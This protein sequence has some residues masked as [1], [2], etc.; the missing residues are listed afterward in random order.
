MRIF[1][2]FLISF[3]LLQSSCKY[4]SDEKLQ[5]AGISQ[6]DSLF[7]DFA[8]S[9]DTLVLEKKQ[10]LA[11]QL[12]SLYA[13]LDPVERQNYHAIL[14]SK[15]FKDY[16]SIS[17]LSTID[18]QG[19]STELREYLDFYKL[20]Y[21]VPLNGTPELEV[22]Q[23]ILKKVNQEGAEKNR[24]TYL[25]YEALARIYFNNAD[26]EKSIHYI[27]LWYKEHPNRSM[28]RIQFTFHEIMFLHM[29]KGQKL[30]QMGVHLQ[31]MKKLLQSDTN[32]SEIARIY[33]KEALY[34]GTKGQSDS[35]I[36]Y[37]NKCIEIAPEI[38]MYYRNLAVAYQREKNYDR[39]IDI[40]NEGIEKVKTA[41]DSSLFYSFYSTLALSYEAKGDYKKAL[42]LQGISQHYNLEK[43][44]RNQ[45]EN[46]SA[47]ENRYKS[48]NRDL[49]IKNLQITDSLK[50][51]IIVQQKWLIFVFFCFVLLILT[52]MY[53]RYK[54]GLIKEKTEKLQIESE[55]LAVENDMLKLE[56]RAL[57]LKLN[58]HFIHNTI[59]NLQG[60]ILEGR[61]EEANDYLLKFSRLLRN[62]L[63]YDQEE[64]VPLDREIGLIRDYLNLQKMRFGDNFDYTLEVDTDP[65]SNIQVPLM[66]IQ[67]FVENA[68]IHGFQGLS[69]KGFLLVKF[70]TTG[71]S[72]RILITDNGQGEQPKTGNAKNKK[73][74][75]FEITEKR[76]KAL[77]PDKEAYIRKNV[78]SVGFEVELLIPIIH[79][80]LHS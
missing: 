66:L 55:K 51:Q 36:F 60:V 7:L 63:D 34:Q 41:S 21:Q 58:P 67:P 43:T 17:E 37:L 47:I 75:S 64:W 39:A 29:M 78:I 50:S 3:C 25:Y 26:S 19:R 24:F 1:I 65:V 71:D 74:L 40:A 15:I 23:Q 77:F 33:E 30:D 73:S 42:E 28:A 72:L 11:V 6:K 46:I 4:F 18:T 38:P 27:Q 9:I 22:L 45:L 14:N 32:K 57:Q 69:R 61:N 48:E 20:N 13:K 59:S 62:I 31:A 53:F 68:I 56:Q 16:R 52:A 54:R 44:K 8:I 35:A 12:D 10:L 49:Q 70:M 76:L 5:A 80:T 2:Y 79:D